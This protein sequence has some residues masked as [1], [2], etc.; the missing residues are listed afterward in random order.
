MFLNRESFVWHKLHSLTGIVP[1]GFYMIQHLTLNSFSLMGPDYFNAVIKF[2]GELLPK[3]ILWALEIVVLA[4]PILYHGIY[5]LFIT[6]RA[7]SNVFQ[8]KYRFRENAMYTLQRYTGVVLFLLLIAHVWTT[9][10]NSKIHG[11]EVI[12]YA[13]WH[14]MLT[15]HGHIVLIL[16][17]IGIVLASYHLSYGIWNFCIRWGITVSEKAQLGL[18]KISSCVF[19]LVTL[20][21]WAA[22][23][24]FVN[25]VLQPGGA[26]QE[27]NGQGVQ[28]MR[29]HNARVASVH[30]VHIPVR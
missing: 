28:V 10:L 14:E 20:L 27:D 26:A 30:G 6:Q 9:T 21:G 11:E 13:A 3:H 19:V 18:R 2:F 8:P 24:G 17:M 25:P 15:S 5:G 23:I 4:L 12:K 29:T 16:Y 1:V 22:L 7:Q